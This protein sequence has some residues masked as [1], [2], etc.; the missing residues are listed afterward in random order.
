VKRFDPRLGLADSEDLVAEA[1]GLPPNE[2][3]EEIVGV[4]ERGRAG[5]GEVSLSSPPRLLLSLGRL[6][7]SE[8]RAPSLPHT[9]THYI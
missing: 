9:H 4:P 7:L 5:E 1:V 6:L 3:R 8:G 2:E